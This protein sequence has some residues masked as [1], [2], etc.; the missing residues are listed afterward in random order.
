ME[1]I[2]EIKIDKNQKHKSVKEIKLELLDWLFNLG[3]E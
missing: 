3:D 1:E 2:K